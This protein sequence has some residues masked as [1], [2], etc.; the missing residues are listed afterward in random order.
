[1]KRLYRI[2]DYKVNNIIYIAENFG[3]IDKINTGILAVSIEY[4]SYKVREIKGEYLI[5]EDAT[6]DYPKTTIEVRHIELTYYS[7]FDTTLVYKC[8]LLLNHNDTN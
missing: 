6:N 1:M 7:V 4:N 5:L 3:F 8:N 2:E